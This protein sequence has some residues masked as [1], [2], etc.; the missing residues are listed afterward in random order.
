MKYIL[1]IL[2]M[3]L[4]GCGADPSNK[5]TIGELKFLIAGQSNSVSSAD[6]HP[7]MVSSTGLVTINDYHRNQSRFFTPTVLDPSPA[8]VSWIHLGDLL[9]RKVTFNI[10]GEGGTNTEM[11]VGRSAPYLGDQALYLRIQ[12]ALMQQ[13]Y[14]AVLWVQGESDLINGLGEELS[15]QN[16]RFIIEESRR[17]QPGLVWFVALNSLSSAVE[18][19]FVRRAQKRIIAEGIAF[20]GADLD[21][22]HRGGL[23]GVDLV[24]SD[25]EWHGQAWFEIL[26]GYL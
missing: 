11:W 21:P 23:G 2:T 7:P 4:V 17:V 14:D 12:N 22:I 6:Q 18:D 15:Y 26:K 8:G 13:R 10:V 9:N 3:G 1:I 19:N 5:K 24:G 25:L 20:E 16:L